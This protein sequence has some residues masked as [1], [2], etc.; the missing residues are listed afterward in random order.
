[1]Y[2][3]INKKRKEKKSVALISTPLV[4]TFTPRCVSPSYC[5]CMYIFCKKFQHFLRINVKSLYILL[6]EKIRGRKMKTPFDL[7]VVSWKF[8]GF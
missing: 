3:Q 7:L 6:I 2:I 5:P 1:M 8:F 4:S